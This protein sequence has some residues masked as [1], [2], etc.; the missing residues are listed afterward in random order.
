MLTAPCNLVIRLKTVNVCIACAARSKAN[1]PA[2][3]RAHKPHDR[4]LQH[5]SRRLMPHKHA[6]SSSKLLVV[7]GSINSAEHLHHWVIWLYLL[8]PTLHTQL[9]FHCVPPAGFCYHMAAQRSFYLRPRCLFSCFKRRHLWTTHG[10][11]P[12]HSLH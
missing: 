12:F 1:R 11:M 10:N 9:A 4:A 5:V 7:E 3:M 8:Q 2:M 6:C